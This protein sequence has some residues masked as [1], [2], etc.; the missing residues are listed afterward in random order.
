MKIV[1]NGDS[2]THERHFAI[3]E[4]YKEKTWAHKIGAENIA[5]GGCSNEHIFQSSIAYLNDNTPDVLVIGWTDFDRYKMTHP[6]G[7]NLHI[8]GGTVSDDLLFG[9]KPGQEDQYE[10]YGKFYYK[11]M[12]NPYLNIKNWITYYLHLE[13]YCSSNGIIF[14]NFMSLS[15]PNDELLKQISKSAY[16]ARDNKDIETQGINYNYAL[17]K[18]GLARFKEE[19]WINGKIGFCYAD[20][21][22]HLPKWDKGHPGLEASSLWADIVQKNIDQRLC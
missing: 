12:L 1:V 3:G 20:H 10:E 11:K 7:L 8:C 17:L 21:V 13:K 2:F 6:N 5:L 14:L 22:A 9:I 15:F 19:N 18:K 16:M 4:D